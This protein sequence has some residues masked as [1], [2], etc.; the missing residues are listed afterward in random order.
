MFTDRWWIAKAAGA[1]LLFA[2]LSRH[3]ADT[4]ERLHP[5]LERAALFTDDIKD[6]SFVIWGKKVLT[7]DAE[8]FE[9][10][11]HVGP[12]R[13]LATTPPRVGDYVSA[14]ARPVGPRTLRASS[15]QINAGWAWKRP[16]NYAVS[17]LLVL[18]YLRYHRRLFR[19]NAEGGIL[20]G[21]Y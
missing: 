10:P 17:I 5:D 13:I 4:L 8:G 16:L 1:L 7:A 21:R 12:M 18:G 6:R 9:V 20:R 19:W 3:S 2:V 15:I 11:S 14:I